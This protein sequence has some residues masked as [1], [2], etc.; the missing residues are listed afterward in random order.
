M[1]K[2]LI[3]WSAILLQISVYGQQKNVFDIARNGT[4]KE[5]ENS[6]IND[7]DTI[8]TIDPNG[9]TPLILACYHGNKDVALFIA[10]KAKDI[11]YKSAMGTALMAAVVK[12][13]AEIVKELINLKANT[14][15]CDA[16]GKTALIYAVFFNK[17]EI[18]KMLIQAGANTSIKGNDNK[19]AY[20]FALNNK[21]TE[22]IILLDK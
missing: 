6:F 2:I 8:N 17:N 7:P 20:D 9:F 13:D 3:L 15:S 1:D 22:L 21:N 4:L 12:G 11:N 10:Q 16:N 14:D 18:A 19:T 5:I